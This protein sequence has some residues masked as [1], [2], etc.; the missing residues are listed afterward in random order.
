MLYLIETRRRLDTF[1]DAF[2]NDFYKV[3]KRR[4]DGF[5]RETQN[6]DTIRQ[7]YLVQYTQGLPEDMHSRSKLV[8]GMCPRRSPSGKLRLPILRD[9]DL[10]GGAER[11]EPP[12][13]PLSPSEASPV[14]AKESG[15]RATMSLSNPTMAISLGSSTKLIN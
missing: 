3:L 9:L 14:G 6:A 2:T 11:A 5:V 15:A 4:V 12:P 7:S 8:A 1:M 10:E 13:P